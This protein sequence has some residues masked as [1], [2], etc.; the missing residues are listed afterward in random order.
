MM[1]NNLVVRTALLE[2]Y[3]STTDIVTG[4]FSTSYRLLSAS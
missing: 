3:D 1:P 2:K 4:K